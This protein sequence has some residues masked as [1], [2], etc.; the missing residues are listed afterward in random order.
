MGSNGSA[1][2]TSSGR[3]NYGTSRRVLAGK[4]LVVTG[5]GAAA[6]S[7]ESAAPHVL[8]IGDKAPDIPLVNQEGKTIRF[9]QFRE[10]RPFFSRLFTRAVPFPIIVR[11]SVDNSLSSKKSGEQ[12]QRLQ[13]NTL[14]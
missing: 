11:C 5:K 14:D 4:H 12:S 10:G 3:C 6:S 1:G 8:M 2:Q 7:T 13:K 9:G